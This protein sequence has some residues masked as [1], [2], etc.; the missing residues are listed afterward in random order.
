[1]VKCKQCKVM[2]DKKQSVCQKINCFQCR[3]DCFYS[4]FPHH[5]REFSLKCYCI[6]EKHEYELEILQRSKMTHCDIGLCS[7]QDCK[8]LYIIIWD[9]KWLR[10]TRSLNVTFRVIIT[11]LFLLSNE[12]HF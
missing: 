2:L 4:H 5:V 7:I 6:K 12:N 1:M 9:V 3:M 10:A 11:L 8:S